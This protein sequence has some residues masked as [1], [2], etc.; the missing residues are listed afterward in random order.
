MTSDTTEPLL[1]VKGLTISFGRGRYRNVV[2][3]DL[4]YDLHPGETLAIVG[5]SGSGKSVSS[6]ALLGLLPPGAANVESGTASFDGQ[7]LLQLSDE[8]LRGIRGDRVTMIFQEPMTSLTPVLRIGQQLTEALI[9]HK[10]MSGSEAAARGREMLTLVGLDKVERRMR[11][12]P[13][14]LSGGMRQRVMI[15]MAMASDPAIL[16]ADEP[17]TALDVTVQAQI[18]DLMR[19]LKTKFGTSIILITHDMGVVAEMADRVVVMRKGVKIEEG[20]VES[21]FEVPQHD[22]TKALLAAVP[23][24]GAHAAAA[25]P[26]TVVDDP[27][28]PGDRLLHTEGMSKTFRERGLFVAKSGGTAAMQD[29][30]FDLATGE[31]LA[32][33]GE[34]GSGKSTTGRAVLRLLDL[35]EGVI[36]IGGTDMR[37]LSGTAVR[38]ARREMQMIFQDP[39]ASLNPRLSAGRLVAEPMVIHGLASGKELQDRTEQLFLRVGLEADHMRRFPHEF[40]GGQRQRLSIARALS[41]NPKLI[42]ADEPTS[43]LDVSVQAQVLELMLEL[44][45]SLG[46]AYLFISHDMAVVEEVAHRVAVMRR[47]RIVEIGPRQA[48]LNDPHHAYTRALLAA[49]PVP[50][51]TRTRGTL[52]VLDID[53]LPMGPLAEVAPQHMVAS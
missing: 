14:E 53:Q 48:V 42:V 7:D 27:A 49:V 11:Q 22:Y 46:L 5:E 34:S 36:E 37:K 12:F 25:Q 39:F 6:M 28:R 35:D 31:T 24:L 21:I 19:D 17:T 44:Q 16:L 3:K 52:P 23:R 51:P 2:V 47:G 38:K 50:D 30:G 33:V 40:S 41:V 9:E 4:S 10:G 13:H 45:Q 32:L 29:V 20:P 8:E 18:L 26:R 1:S 43:A 15:A